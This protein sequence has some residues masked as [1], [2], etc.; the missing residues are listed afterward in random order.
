[1]GLT[2]CQVKSDGI[3]SDIALGVTDC[4]NLSAQDGLV[5]V[6]FSSSSVLVGAHNRGIDHRV[7]VLASFASA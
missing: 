5:L 6:F 7:L 2:F 1:M 4:M 3:T